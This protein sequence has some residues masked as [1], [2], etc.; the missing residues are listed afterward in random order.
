MKTLNLIAIIIGLATINA[1]ATTF[2]QQGFAS[3]LN[4]FEMDAGLG[5]TG[6]AKAGLVTLDYA[7]KIAKLVLSVSDQA[8]LIVV[9]L[10]IKATKVNE[11]GTITITAERSFMDGNVQTMVITDNSQ[12]K[13][14]D[15]G[16]QAA[17]QVELQT[18][19]MRP[20]Q[21]TRSFFSGKVL[22]PSTNL[23]FNAHM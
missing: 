18:Q 8:S 19:S 14:G 13:C 7:K 12:A 6:N 21:T 1:N 20:V 22:A 2:S 15:N 10:P 23:D 16:I 5:I 11:C 17:T 9:Q 3:R 4:S